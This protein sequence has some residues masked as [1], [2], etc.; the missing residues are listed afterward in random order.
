MNSIDIVIEESL[1][2]VE[3]DDLDELRA[4]YVYSK[5]ARKRE[6]Q[7]RKMWTRH[8]G[9]DLSPLGKEILAKAIPVLNGAIAIL[10]AS[11]PGGV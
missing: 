10:A 9:K 3:F 5:V 11:E 8:S 2:R 7:F 4:L 1:Y 6:K